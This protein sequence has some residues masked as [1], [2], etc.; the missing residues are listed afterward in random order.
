MDIF[1]VTARLFFPDMGEVIEN[2]FKSS[3]SNVALLKAL[4]WYSE[5]AGNNDTEN[6]QLTLTLNGLTYKA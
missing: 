1:T 3:L 5:I 6:F 4:K 2:S